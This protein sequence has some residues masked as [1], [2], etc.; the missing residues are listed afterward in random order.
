VRSAQA[1]PVVERRQLTVMFVDLVGSTALAA[2]MDAEDMHELLQAYRRAVRQ[3]VEAAG[4]HAAGFP[5]DGVVVCF[6]WPQALEDAAERAVRA[7]LQVLGT[8]TRISAPDGRPLAARVG[9]ATGVVV[10]DG[11]KG[12]ADSLTGGTPNL[13][14]RL[15]SVAEPGG[16]VIAAGT[17]ELVGDL[18]AIE[19]L[20]PR[21]VKG[22]PAPVRVF[23]VTARAPRSAGSRRG[24]AAAWRRWSAGTASW[25][26]SASAGT[27]R[28]TA[29]A[30]PCC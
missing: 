7:G 30:R 11:S 29:K 25:P 18:F 10:V 20:G 15:Q 14:A 9:I 3:V 23:R 2:D 24:T 12:D 21:E 6:G 26:C 1:E 4:G 19:D 13:A 17:R 5:G 22:L 16:L 28:G 27:G 8:I